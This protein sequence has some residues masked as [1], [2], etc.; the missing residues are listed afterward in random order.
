MQRSAIAYTYGTLT[1]T[2]TLTQMHDQGESIS[3]VSRKQVAVTAEIT[4]E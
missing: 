3:P 2:A 1:G 4:S